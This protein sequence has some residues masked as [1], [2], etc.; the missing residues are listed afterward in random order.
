MCL[1]VKI[2]IHRKPKFATEDIKCY[3][4][5]YKKTH[6]FLHY[7]SVVFKHTW[8]P[9]V[10]YETHMSDIQFVGSGNGVINEGFHAIED[11]KTAM[12][13]CGWDEVLCE[14]KIPSG[15]YYWIGYGDEIVSNKMMLVKELKDNDIC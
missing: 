5:L 12:H 4:Y 7:K 15:A 9:D 10:V 8:L 6:P 13:L 1:E 11:L 2:H 3:K 14:M